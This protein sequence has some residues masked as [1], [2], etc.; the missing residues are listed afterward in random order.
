MFTHTPAA[1]KEYLFLGFQQIGDC[2]LA[3]LNS[4]IHLENLTEST[5]FPVT[6]DI[7]FL[8][9]KIN[10]EVPVFGAATPFALFLRD[11][12]G[13]MMAGGNGSV[14]FG[15]IYTDQLWVHPAYRK[16][17]LGH[18]L[19]D[20]AHEY[21]KKM[22]CSMATVNT[23]SLQCSQSFYEKLGYR[24]DFQRWGYH[25]DSVCLFIRKAVLRQRMMMAKTEVGQS[26]FSGTTCVAR[27]KKKGL[28]FFGFLYPVA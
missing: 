20:E 12:A 7:D 5:T 13:N 18:Q 10:E 17:G 11:E 24:V 3:L 15:C 25:Q 9:Q 23:I 1:I 4:P 2:R 6:S 16:N 14:I 27:K 8:M 28:N 22:G 19:M 26:Y 21:R